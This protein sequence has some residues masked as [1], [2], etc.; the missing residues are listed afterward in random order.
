MFQK[1]KA[2]IASSI[3]FLF[4][5][6]TIPAQALDR[7]HDNDR[8][9]EQRIRKAENNLQNAIRKHGERSRQAE[10]RRHQLDEAREQ[11]HRGD[12]DRR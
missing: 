1:G 6:G 3:V 10:Q 5:A 2:L 11:C 8:K 7:D 12:H 9:C 4:L